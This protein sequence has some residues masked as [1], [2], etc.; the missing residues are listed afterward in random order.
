MY[1]K[2]DPRCN[3]E[4][5]KDYTAYNAIRGAKMRE[6]SNYKEIKKCEVWERNTGD[7]IVVLADCGD[8]A[9]VTVLSDFESN[10]NDIEIKFQGE[11]YH[12]ICSKLSY[13]FTDTFEKRLG[14]M[15]PAEVQKIITGIQTILGVKSP[16][17]TLIEAADMLDAKEE[18]IK[19]LK[20]ENILLKGKCEAYLDILKVR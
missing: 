13:R 19:T 10:K 11:T 12:T 18:E 17:K 2:D 20:E 1:Y 7:R 9:L 8:Y 16:S 5:Y 15:D 6:S 14:E 4:G 3:H